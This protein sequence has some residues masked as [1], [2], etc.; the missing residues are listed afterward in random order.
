MSIHLR[1]S[2]SRPLRRPGTANA[3]QRFP[4]TLVWTHVTVLHRLSRS[5][6][7]MRTP[8]RVHNREISSDDG[9]LESTDKSIASTPLRMQDTVEETTP[10]SRPVH[11]RQFHNE[12]R[13]GFG[14]LFDWLRMSAFAIALLGVSLS[15]YLPPAFADDM[16][17]SDPFPAEWN[18]LFLPEMTS[19]RSSPQRENRTRRRSKP[20]RESRKWTKKSRRRTRRG[21]KGRRRRSSRGRRR[22]RKAVNVERRMRI[23]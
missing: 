12:R 21:W 8:T 14:N 17:A 10:R 16:Y 22:R 20:T 13:F 11:F 2:R 19:L 5:P 1:P 3:L 9:V 6:R 23:V 15:G 18:L 4:A 7:R